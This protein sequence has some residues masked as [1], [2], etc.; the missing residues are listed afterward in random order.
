MKILNQADR[1]AYNMLKLINRMRI[2]VQLIE[3]NPT[4]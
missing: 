3:F 1:Y 2:W 4:T